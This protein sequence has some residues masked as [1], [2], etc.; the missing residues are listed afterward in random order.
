MPS[1]KDKKAAQRA[2]RRPAKYSFRPTWNRQVLRYVFAKRLPFVM[3]D[4]E[5]TGTDPDKDRVIQFAGIR[6]SFDEAG[7]LV[8]DGRVVTYID[9]PVP[10]SPGASRANGITSRDLE[11]APSE[12][13][14]FAEI[15]AL[16]GPRPVACGYNILAFDNAMMKEMYARNGAE[17]RP[18]ATL[19]VS[20]LVRDFVPAERDRGR[21]QAEMAALYGVD[22]G[23]KFHD[24]AADIEACR[25]LLLCMVEEDARTAMGGKAPIFP[26]AVWWFP[27]KP[28]PDG[29]SQGAAKLRACSRSQHGIYVRTNV[30]LFDKKTGREQAVTIW[31]STT[32]KC[33]YSGRIDFSKY[34]MDRFT[35][36]VLRMLGYRASGLQSAL[37]AMSDFGRLSERKLNAR[38]REVRERE[39]KDGD[40]TEC[41]AAEG[42]AS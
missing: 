2:A 10:I 33:W 22:D 16:F 34:D 27:K 20:E 17:F 21:T 40:A 29:T 31:Y 3:Y 19:D 4:T 35:V 24:A 8:E 39:R 11:G 15:A 41:G 9:Q 14:A 23:I 7:R 38:M 36:A 42:G 28:V 12:Q 25:R 32:D 18:V 26:Q 5:T 6:Y 1:D 13:E 30:F 37:E